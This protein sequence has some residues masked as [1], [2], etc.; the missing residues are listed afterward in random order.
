[1]NLLAALLPLV[2]LLASYAIGSIW[3]DPG[4]TLALFS[5]LMGAAVSCG[6]ARRRGVSW[7]EIQQRTGE[8]LT[9]VL[10]AITI[11]LAIGLL[12]GSWVLSG[13]IPMLVDFGLKW[14]NPDFFLPSAFVATAVMSLCTGTS[15]G[16]AATLGVALMGM[17]TALGISPAM[18]AGAVVSG[19]YVGDKLSPLSDTTNICAIA[20]NVPLYTH[21][22]Y[23]LF[24]VVPALLVAGS[25]YA[26]LGTPGS[27]ADT[28][29]HALVV[30]IEQSFAIGLWAT[31]PVVLVFT[32][33]VLRR[34]A[35]LTLIAGALL[36]TVIGVLVQGFSPGDA[37]LT[38]IDGFNVDMLPSETNPSPALIT[39]LNRGG[40]NSMAGTVL[41]IL[42]AFL[43]AAGLELSGALDRIVG[44]LLSWAKSIGRLVLATMATGSLLVSL[45]SHAS[46]SALMV[47]DI[48]RRRYRDQ[49]LAP[50]NLSRNM[51]D[52]ITIVE[53]LL[54]WTVSAL[55]MATTLGVPTTEYL[56]WAVFCYVGPLLAMA[57]GLVGQRFL[58]QVAADGVRIGNR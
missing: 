14:M 29:A 13:T 49:N 25:A 3:I 54:P 22:R 53:P 33:I 27:A 34:P 47:G 50:E 21:V 31:L 17:A 44:G 52:S 20:A 30:E 43:L 36:A 15:W 10:P 58:R 23:L 24:T 35:A 8:K 41:L 5:L 38:L 46:V 57:Y 16:S 2:V 11:L 56:P 48:F 32:G 6:Q 7:G 37:I 4:T 51:E 28:S 12:I 26:V 9:A 1:M 42:T 55:F 40:L 19:A 18:T 45:T 39:L